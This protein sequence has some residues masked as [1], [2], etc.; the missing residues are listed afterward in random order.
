MLFDRR[1]G[2]DVIDR[3]GCFELL[4]SQ[5]VGRLA[6]LEGGAPLILPVNYALDGEAIVLRTSP[7][8][9]LDASHGGPACFEIDHIDPAHRAGW[10]VVVRGHLH[11]VTPY[12]TTD[13]E[14]VVDMT[15]SWVNNRTHVVELR[16]WSVT[17]R[18]L[19]GGS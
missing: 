11:E 13:L 9:K 4:A 2:V 5:V 18:R 12:D 16:P 6:V 10:S 1:T 15:D 7:G 8:S 19:Q 14:R 3:R 17:G